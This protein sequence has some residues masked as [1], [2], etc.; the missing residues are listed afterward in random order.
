MSVRPESLPA[1]PALS[2]SEGDLV[3]VHICVKPHLLERLLDTLASVSF[4]INPQIYHQAGVG[5]VFAD[6][7]EEIEPTTIVEFPAFSARLPE[8]RAVLKVNGLPAESMHVWGMLDDIHSD[9]SSEA[10]PEGSPYRRV[11]L[12]KHV[13]DASD[14]RPI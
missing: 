7:R 5:H 10:A 12:Y 13:P 9:R 11:N 3:S 6:G 4:P 14:S 8:V 2:G 1:S